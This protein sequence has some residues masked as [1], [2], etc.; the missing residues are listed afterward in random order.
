MALENTFVGHPQDS[1][2]RSHLNNPPR[3]S[4]KNSCIGICG[5]VEDAWSVYVWVSHAERSFE[6][7]QQRAEFHVVLLWCSDSWGTCQCSSKSMDM[8]GRHGVDCA[9]SLCRLIMVLLYLNWLIMVWVCCHLLWL[10]KLQGTKLHKFPSCWAVQVV[11]LSMLVSFVL[12]GGS[13]F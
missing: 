2:V 1:R 12:F 4:N 9:E 6:S 5:G 8:F 10:L 13:S 3:M 7:G 11:C